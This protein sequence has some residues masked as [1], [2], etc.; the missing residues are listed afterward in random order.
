MKIAAGIIFALLASPAYAKP[1]YLNCSTTYQSDPPR[2]FSVTLDEETG[3]VTHQFSNGMTFSA[4]GHFK[5][6]E[7]SYEKVNCSSTCM[8]Q[9]FT[10]DRVD[11]SVSSKLIISA[12]RVGASAPLVSNGK[13]TLQAAPD[14][15]F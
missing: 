3:K 15:K 14:R 12:G 6:D 13:C 11:L 4:D 5:A 7:V 10:I 8:T 1:V 9:Q 2:E